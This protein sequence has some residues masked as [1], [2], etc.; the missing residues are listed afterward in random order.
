MDLHRRP[1]PEA[2]FDHWPSERASGRWNGSNNVADTAS[3]QKKG[4][5]R[6]VERTFDVLFALSDMPEGCGL[7]DLARYAGLSGATTLRIVRTLAGIN[8]VSF[9]EKTRQ[10]SL[11]PA[12][13]RFAAASLGR[14]QLVP[15]A[16][17]LLER[18]RDETQE[19]T[20]IFQRSRK[21]RV[22]VAAAKCSRELSFHIEPGQRR[23][24][25]LGS[26]GKVLLAYMPRQDR[27]IFY[28]SAR[29]SDRERLKIEAECK[30][31]L[32][33]GVAFSRDELVVG[34][35]ALAAPIF[36]QVGEVSA[37]TI[38]GPTARLDKSRIEILMPR[39]KRVAA[40]ISQKLGWQ[41]GGP[42]ARRTAS[43]WTADREEAESRRAATPARTPK[44]TNS[45]SARSTGAIMRTS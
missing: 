12:M 33:S 42:V 43:A 32:A 16:Q 15:T 4:R 40:Q 26:P 29:I 22:C 18:L 35:A 14:T 36:N 25:L 17:E 30:Q 5:T 34:G 24:M 13:Y 9:D 39:I 37:L 31:V 41:E 2:E 44:R 3:S 21:D 8:A 28:D 20:C 23:S 7:N 1:E 45:K 27:S 19:T 11:G 6:L 38:L 10:Y